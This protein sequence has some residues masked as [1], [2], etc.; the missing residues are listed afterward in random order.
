[1]NDHKYINI[2]RPVLIMTDVHDAIAEASEFFP[3]NRLGEKI[4]KNL[5]YWA[6]IDGD[7]LAFRHVHNKEIPDIHVAGVF[8]A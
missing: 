4:P 3:P 2:H 7:V 6:V 1:M 8:A 5:V